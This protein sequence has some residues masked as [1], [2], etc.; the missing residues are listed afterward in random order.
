MASKN[1][2]KC[3]ELEGDARRDKLLT[4]ISEND[5]PINGTEL[6]RMLNVSR[7]VIV[8]DIALLRA[9]NKNIISTNKGY[10]IY[11]DKSHGARK[12]FK[13]SHSDSEVLDEL[14]IIVDNGGRL[15]DVVIEHE[16]Y[17]QI[18][19]DLIIN[20]RRD[21]KE[22]VNKLKDSNAKPLSTLTSGEH[23]HTVVADS[24]E[25]IE[26]VENALKKA[27]YLL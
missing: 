13:V 4:I 19:V 7:Q 20:N 17:G 27:G 5:A 18:S 14:N 6:A 22:F 21:V 1:E 10:L 11:D 24:D 12:T 3:D 16:I 9:C 26:D 8:Q 2:R 25:A 15:L 23:Y